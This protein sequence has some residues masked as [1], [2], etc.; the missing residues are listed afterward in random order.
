MHEA[1]P[2]GLGQRVLAVTHDYLNRWVIWESSWNLLQAAPWRGAGLGLFYLAYPPF[3]N[4]ADSSGGFFVHNDYLQIW[5]EAGLPGLLLLISVQIAALWLLVRTL[6][7]KTLPRNTRI[8]TVGLFC[9]L[10][11]VAVHSFVDFN[12]YILSIMMISGLV[13]GRL[14]ELGC[15]ELKTP[16]VRIRFSHRIGARAYP[17]IVMLLVLLPILYFTT[18]GLAN[19]YYEKA[20]AQGREARLREA[21]RS[22][23]TAEWLAPADDRILIARADLY[24]HAITLLPREDQNGKEALYANALKLLD[25]ARREN[26]LRALTSVIRARL[27]RQNPALAGA[28]GDELAA[29]SFHHALALNPR[30]LL[31]RMEY[32]ELLL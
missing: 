18:L 3:S 17:A 1:N 10:L 5:I 28:K 26:S 15:R 12:L 20:L 29:E 31:G 23:A 11:A 4:P 19:S 16:C 21:D 6:R 13:M 27:Y 8:E 24:R 22:L 32:A 25:E 30:L 9:G 14:H 2:R 7:K